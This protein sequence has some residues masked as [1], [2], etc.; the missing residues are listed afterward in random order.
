MPITTVTLTGNVRD[1]IGNA[2]LNK[3]RPKVW[4]IA[5]DANG[6]IDR[7]ADPDSNEERFGNAVPSSA[8]AADGTYTFTNL[9][10]TNAA[11]NPT[12]FY[13]EVF[14]DYALAR[15]VGGRH[16]NGGRNTWSSGPFE[17]IASAAMADLDLD[18]PAV[19]ATWRSG[20]RDEMEAIRDEVVDLSGI[21]T[22]DALL[23]DRINT[24]GSLTDIGLSATY[25]AVVGVP[26][27][28][29]VAATDTANIDAAL[30]AAASSDRT[31][32]VQL[33]TGTYVSNGGH[34][35]PKGVTV[36]G[37]GPEETK[38]T[39]L[40]NN[41]CFSC[42]DHTD[43]WRSPHW[44]GFTIV[45]N[46]GAS[47]CGIHH[48][49]SYMTTITDVQVEGYTGGVGI[50]VHN[51][52]IWTEGAEFVRVHLRNNA[53][54][55]KFSRSGTGTDSF[56]ELR[57]HSVSI[58]IGNANGIGIDIGAGCLFYGALLDVKTLQPAGGSIGILLDPTAIV[59]DSF[60]RI[61]IEGSGGIG[62]QAPAGSRFAVNGAVYSEANH[63]I[64]GNYVDKASIG[65][66]EWV[67]GP[68]DDGPASRVIGPGGQWWRDNGDA[69]SSRVRTLPA[70]NP[71]TRYYQWTGVG[72]DFYNFAVRLDGPH[73]KF[74]AG[75][76]AAPGSESLESNHP[77][78]LGR[79]GVGF[80][81]TNP[82]AKP[83]VSGSKGGNAALGSLIDALE[84]LGLITDSTT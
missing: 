1:Q 83:T 69:T 70:G 39:H 67:A 9:W 72:S 37:F 63:Y 40:G 46:N 52:Q 75:P 80:Y 18:T 82:Q 5:R 49:N 43:Q 55:L 12:G 62:I 17:L 61:Y 13:Y 8:I 15:G 27:P 2:D 57:L 60:A 50:H 38:I 51:S 74:Q 24:P 59:R 64:N 73:L 58:G 31:A 53:R 56:S 19:S 79:G 30:T 44:R 14:V 11:T 81:G 78:A 4:L 54:N 45:G 32:V 26:E 20:F 71:S 68:G 76:G 34:V 48:G 16:S 47:A 23:A 10:P 36:A 66:V 25:A 35:V 28:T 6:P 3:S 65:R 29:G 77:L 84:A 42:L 33:A 22:A 21:S 7:I 41:D